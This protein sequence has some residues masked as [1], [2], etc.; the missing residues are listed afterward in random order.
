MMAQATL[1]LVGQI[2]EVEQ[3]DD[4]IIVIP[5]MD[6]REMDYQRIEAEAREILELL[7]DTAIMNVIVDFGK[8]DYFGST[9]LG[10]FLNRWRAVRGR[11]GRI[12]FCNLSDHERDI[13]Q[14]T[15]LNWLWP[16]YA[17]RSEALEAVRQP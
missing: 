13:L 8:T 15:H 6:L 3:E 10:V 2:F 16:I 5:V 7:N 11:K 1:A 9:A 12:A 14:I 4:T 17:S